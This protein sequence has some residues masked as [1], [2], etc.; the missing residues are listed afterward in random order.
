MRI[1]F[2]EATDQHESIAI[3]ILRSDPTI[4]AILEESEAGLCDLVCRILA[5]DRSLPSWTWQIISGGG[6]NADRGNWSAVD[7]VLAG[8]TYGRYNIHALTDALTLTKNQGLAIKESRVDAMIHFM[9]SRQAMYTQV[10][11]HRVLIAAD[12]LEY[13]V[14]K[15]ARDLGVDSRLFPADPTMHKLLEAKNIDELG[16]PDINCCRESWYRYHLMLWRSSTDSILADLADRVINRRLF[17][18]IRARS[19]A[20][21]EDLYFRCQKSCQALGFD[22]TYYLHK[23]NA[24]H[25]EDLVRSDIL[26]SMPVITDSGQELSL[27]DT[28]PF[29]SM[30]AR[31]LPQTDPI[32]N[33]KVWLAVPKEVKEITI[34]KNKAL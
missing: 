23:I 34:G 13:S 3:K 2:P 28:D 17:K 33:P 12:H 9:I 8:V 19:I 16:L 18:T 22:P 24:P 29:A 31:S 15:R 25:S 5:E 30:V 1:W 21:G 10:Y 26:A 11:H 6:W 14:I 4:R 27:A 7:S 32:G 20:E